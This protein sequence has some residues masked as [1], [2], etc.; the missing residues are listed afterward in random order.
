LLLEAFSALRFRFL[1]GRRHQNLPILDGL[2][3]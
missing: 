3:L 2:Y 1:L